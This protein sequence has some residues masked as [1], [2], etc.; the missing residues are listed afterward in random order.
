MSRTT[1]DDGR[2]D[3][4]ELLSRSDLSAEQG[5]RVYNSLVNG[6]IEGWA[7]DIAISNPKT[8][9]LMPGSTG[10]WTAA[11]P[12]AISGHCSPGSGTYTPN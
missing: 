8:R 1:P 7:P 2:L 12:C 3:L 9:F 6:M 4:S 11:A 10:N 5:R